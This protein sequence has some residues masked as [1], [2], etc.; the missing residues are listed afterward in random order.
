MNCKNCNAELE[1]GM[2]F[3]PACGAAQAEPETEAVEVTETVETVEAPVE[4]TPAVEEKKTGLGAGKIALL[5]T[6]AVAAVAVVI[7][8]ILGGKGGSNPGE[9]TAPSTPAAT[10]PA[11]AMTVPADGNPDDVTC[12]GSYSAEEKELKKQ[13]DKVVATMGDAK[14]TNSELQVYYWM[15]VYDFLNQYGSY[16]SMFGLDYTQPMDRQLSIDGNLTWQQYF[17]DSAM[18]AWANYQATALDAEANGYVLEQEYADYLAELPNSM[19]ESAAQMGYENA[20][21]MV[22]RDMGPGATM[23]GYMKYLSTYYLGYMY[24][25]DTMEQVGVTDAD[26]EAYFDAHAAE[27][28]ENGLVKGDDRYV[29]VRH[30]LI[31]PEGG[32]AG[33]SG[34]TVYSEEE[35]AVAEKK[36]ND[37]LNEWLTKHPDEDGFGVMAETYTQDPGSATNGGLYEDVYMGRMVPEFE[38]KSFELKEG[39]ISEPVKTSY[40]YHIIQKLPI[41]KEALMDD[42]KQ[43]YW[44]IVSAIAAS[45]A[46]AE[47]AKCAETI[48]IVETDAFKALT[49]ANIGKKK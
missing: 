31:S 25:G 29:D 2:N 40:G 45:P 22:Q 21:A 15:Q 47:V 6:L 42:E 17:L 3:C 30:I 5:V 14:L 23:D 12:Q 46:E 49:M 16:A 27:Y 43:T 33:E 38:A 36:A 19:A 9:T 39:E 28:Q 48:E 7:A 11:V 4:E 8:L 1:E 44:E 41:D 20:E 13:G 26:I 32:T 18:K 34:E 10:N 37:V 24:Y 35:W